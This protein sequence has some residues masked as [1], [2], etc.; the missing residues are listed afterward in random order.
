MDEF[1]SIQVSDECKQ[2]IEQIRALMAAYHIDPARLTEICAAER[3][4][5]CYT[6]PIKVGGYVKNKLNPFDN[7]QR[8]DAITIYADGRINYCF[9]EKVTKYEWSEDDAE[10]YE[11]AA[12]EA[13]EKEAT[14][15]KAD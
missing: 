1:E 10:E 8:V 3:E 6:P 14:N 15:A 7:G 11:P 9:H 12:R 4:G 5:R 2:M 13:M